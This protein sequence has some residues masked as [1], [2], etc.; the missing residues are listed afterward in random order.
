MAITISTT[1]TQENLQGKS[2]WWGAPDL[3]ADLAYP[4]VEIEAVEPYLEPL[5]FICQIRCED[6]ATYDTQNLLPHI[7]MLYFFAPIDYFLGEVNSP[8]D[9]KAHPVVL[10]SPSCDNLKP[11]D[12]KWEN[13]E[14]SIF[15]PA[16]SI[17]F[18]ECNG[19][20]CYG[21]ALL[22]EPIQD[23]I[24]A[25]NSGRISL[26]QLD[27]VDR[28]NMRFYD[29]GMYYILISHNDLKAQN[30]NNLK[31]DIFTY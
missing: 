13:S 2:H 6:I 21:L 8:L 22:T 28:W 20:S 7:G 14:E 3:P 27:G 4:F 18:H 30:F 9:H 11:Y 10:Y 26:L 5:T 25:Y 24:K 12:I 29:C 1:P 16:E 15:R 31:A 23:E 17:S 19:N